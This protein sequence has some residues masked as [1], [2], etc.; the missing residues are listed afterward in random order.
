MNLKRLKYF[1]LPQKSALIFLNSKHVT[2]SII[3]KH[4]IVLLNHLSILKNAKE[5][6]PGLVFM[7]T[8]FLY[9]N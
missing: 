3:S 5:I 6:S 7:Q 9:R 2:I 8:I 1:V 4:N